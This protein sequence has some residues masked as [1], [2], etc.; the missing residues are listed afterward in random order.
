VDASRFDRLSRTLA[1]AGSRRGVLAVLAAL[2]VPGGLLPRQADAGGATTGNGAIAGGGGRR[3]RRRRRNRI[4][5]GSHKG[6]HNKHKKKP[7]RPQSDAQTCAGQCG[8]VTNNCKKQVDCGSC[9]CAPPCPVCQSC[10]ATTGQCRSV[11]DGPACGEGVRCA[12]GRCVCDSTSCAGGCC[13]SGTCHVDDDAACGTGGRSCVACTG[14]NT[15]GGGGTSGQCGCTPTT[16]AAQGKDCGTIPNGCSGELACGDCADPN[17]CGGGGTANV[18][19][20]LANETVTA[21][22]NRGACCGGSCCGEDRQGQPVPPGQC[23][24]DTGCG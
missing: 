12:G 20:C 5:S 16:C 13:Q 9:V 21:V 22:D 24:C 14:P 1:A 8:P 4:H 3:K 19:G 10:D 23:M 15:C 11:P 2:L 6:K 17:I 7:C 18:C